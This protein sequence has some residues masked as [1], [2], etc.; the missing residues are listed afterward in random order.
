MDHLAKA[1][2]FLAAATTSVSDGQPS[3]ATSSS[4]IAAINAKDAMCLALT[5]TTE[6]S[7]DHS[8]AAAELRRAGAVGAACA[9][10]LDRLLR[11]KTR[12]QYQAVAVSATDAAKALERAEKIVAAAERLLLG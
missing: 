7:Q 10:D 4:V 2:E 11:I 12:S 3:A 6:K 5:G 9:N 1:Q 8:V